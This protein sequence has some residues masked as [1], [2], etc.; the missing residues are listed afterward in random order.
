MIMIYIGA[1]SDQRRRPNV[2]NRPGGDSNSA[3]MPASR[4]LFKSS[5]NNG[6]FPSHS[7]LESDG[8]YTCSSLPHT[9]SWWVPYLAKGPKSMTSIMAQEVIQIVAAFPPGVYSSPTRIIALSQAIPI[10]CQM[11][12]TF[13]QVSQLWFPDGCH[14]WTKGPGM[15][16][17][18]AQEVT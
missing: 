7:S 18:I 1:I 14:I 15:T 3:H 5:P 13:V 9:V 16:S 2:N 12:Y 6:P 4:H 8:R 17:I 10:F 11:K